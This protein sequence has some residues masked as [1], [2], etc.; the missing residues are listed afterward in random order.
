MALKLA[1]LGWP[2]AHSLSPV[3]HQA[4]LDAAGIQATY[5]AIAVPPEGLGEV[6]AG[7]RGPGWAGVNVTIPYKEAVLP[8]LDELGPQARRV[9][10]VNTVAN[11]NGRLIGYITDGAGFL[12]HFHAE[13]C[14]PAGRRAVLLGSGGVAR[15][16]AA[17]L[18]GAGIAHLTVLSRSAARGEAVAALAVK[19]AGNGRPSPEVAT[20]PL[21]S[22]DEVVRQLL[23]TAGVVVNC[24]PLG[25]EP[26]VRSSPL[27][28]AVGVL[29]V[30][31]FVYDTVYRPAETR[32][33]VE[34][35]S[36]GLRAVGGLGMLVYQGAL[37]WEVWFG[38]RGPVE[39]M[40]RAVRDA[41]G[42]SDSDKG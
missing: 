8:Y 25:M 33:V 5:K 10:A 40:Q 12:A 2:V 39:I 29:P 13:G 17:A 32:L 37:A 31:C 21:D 1:V 22:A 3:M 15:A 14:D 7:L 11:R 4:A 19:A 42:R 38:R 41:I 18:A 24:T 27:E 26:D 9:G 6:V 30:G 16:I 23:S 35:R 20:G 34:A 28:D 36:R